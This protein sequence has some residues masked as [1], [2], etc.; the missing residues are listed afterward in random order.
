LDEPEL[1]EPELDKADRNQMKCQ[2]DSNLSWSLRS[3][4]ISIDIV[5]VQ[6][7][8]SNAICSKDFLFTFA[9]KH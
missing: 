2:N 7:S 1:D 6:K 5:Y 8:S 9:V 4:L 3:S